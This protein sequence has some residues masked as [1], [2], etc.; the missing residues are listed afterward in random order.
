MKAL[1]ACASFAAALALGP[2]ALA[3]DNAGVQIGTLS[4]HEQSGW[5]MI[6]GSSRRVSCVYSGPAGRS[7]YTGRITDAGVDVGYH[8]SSDLVWAVFAPTS[9]V[10]PGALSG[11]YGG[12]TAGGAIGVGLSANALVGGSGRTIALQPLS[13][14]GNTGL[15]VAAGVAGM[16]LRHVR[17]SFRRD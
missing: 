8:G 2:S 14:S 7:R 6:L 12:A 4:C 3:Y 17:G 9:D 13:V 15:D 11:S 1:L 10:G 5:G 16:T